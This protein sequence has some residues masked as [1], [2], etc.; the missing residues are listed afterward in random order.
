MESNETLMESNETLPEGFIQIVDC[1]KS[2]I[3]SSII[4]NGQT[5]GWCFKHEISVM[6]FSTCKD[7]E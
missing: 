6:S 3:H 5:M 1:C 4:G 7:Y 2:C